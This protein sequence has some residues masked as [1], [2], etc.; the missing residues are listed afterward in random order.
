MGQLAVW[1]NRKTPKKTKTSLVK[2]NQAKFRLNWLEHY[3]L[4]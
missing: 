1:K 2:R 4:A 3:E